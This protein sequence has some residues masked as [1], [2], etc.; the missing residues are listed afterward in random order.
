VVTGVTRSLFRPH[1]LSAVSLFLGANSV[2][3]LTLLSASNRALFVGRT[4]SRVASGPCKSSSCS[5]LGSSSGGVI[6]VLSLSFGF[7]SKPV[8]QTGVFIRQIFR[9]IIF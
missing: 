4:R 2:D 5:F 9:L 1:A 6:T 3:T 8:M 7:K